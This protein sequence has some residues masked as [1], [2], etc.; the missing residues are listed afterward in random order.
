MPSL[1]PT[2]GNQTVAQSYLGGIIAGLAHNKRSYGISSDQNVK[3]NNPQTYAWIGQAAGG[4][5]YQTD[6]E[7]QQNVQLPWYGASTGTTFGYSQ[8][9]PT[10]IPSIAHQV[11]PDTSIALA[12]DPSTVGSTVSALPDAVPI[13]NFNQWNGYQ[14][15]PQ[16][17][18]SWRTY[19]ANQMGNVPLKRTPNALNVMAAVTKQANTS[20]DGPNDVWATHTALMTSMSKN[21]QPARQFWGFTSS[22]QYSGQ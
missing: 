13:G 17:A 20:A 21:Y 14:M 22:Q 2:D 10:D 5:R 1:N 7:A 19:Y 12:P 18:E 4:T 11:T 9:L 8:L 15:N 3:S 6:K 16:N